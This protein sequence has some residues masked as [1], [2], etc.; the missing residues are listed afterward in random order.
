MSV[1]RSLST[2][3]FFWDR[4]SQFVQSTLF[5]TRLLGSIVYL[6]RHHHDHLGQF[7]GVAP[8][9]ITVHF[10]FLNW[11]CQL[12]APVLECPEDRELSLDS[13]APFC[14]YLRKQV[15][16]V[17][18]LIGVG[19]VLLHSNLLLGQSMEARAYGLFFFCGSAVLYAGQL[20]S[21]KK[22]RR[23]IW[24]LAFLAHLALC[25]TH[26]FGI[27][28]SGL[29]AL[30]RYPTMWKRPIKKS[31]TSQIP[32]WII[33]PFMVSFWANNPIIW[34][35]GLGRMSSVTC[36]FLTSIPLILFFCGSDHLLFAFDPTSLKED[37]RKTEE[38]KFILYCSIL[39]ISIYSFGCFLI[40]P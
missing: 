19:G 40:T 28:F 4:H 12:F 3:S 21:T 10:I 9:S 2:S 35:L 16:S 30:S 13:Q 39:W 31:I 34:Q 24:I 25:L 1:D 38:N 8:V 29:A 11:V 18:A 5:L 22:C 15:G 14:L 20:M 32:S 23:A 26:Y 27:V 17:A 37:F 33:S 7:G 6:V 36:W